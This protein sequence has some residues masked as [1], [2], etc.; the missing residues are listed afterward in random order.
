MIV[1]N[2]PVISNNT[3]GCLPVTAYYITVLKMQIGTLLLKIVRKMFQEGGIA[4]RMPVSEITLSPPTIWGLLPAG[5][6]KEPLTSS[7]F[8]QNK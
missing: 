3:Q 4:T 5:F 6:L 7:S 2:G 1:Y 8:P